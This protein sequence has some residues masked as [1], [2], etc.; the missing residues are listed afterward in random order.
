M[1]EYSERYKQFKVADLAIRKFI[2]VTLQNAG[3]SLDA[4]YCRYDHQYLV[5]N[6]ETKR[7]TWN[8]IP[9]RFYSKEVTCDLVAELCLLESVSVDAQVELLFCPV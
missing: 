1:S 3:Y 8:S 6:I 9:T 2:Q 4:D 5:I 7:G